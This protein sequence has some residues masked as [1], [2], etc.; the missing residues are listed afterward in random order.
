MDQDA[1]G[2]RDAADTT[3][4]PS[5]GPQARPEPIGMSV[6][7]GLDGADGIGILRESLVGFAAQAT[8]A[9]AGARD[10]PLT[11]VGLLRAKLWKS[12]YRPVPVYN[13]DAGVESAGKRPLGREWQVD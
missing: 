6:P 10:G 3:T 11:R 5:S 9:Q 8:A 7:D 1:G 4:V 13:P 12:G 2:H